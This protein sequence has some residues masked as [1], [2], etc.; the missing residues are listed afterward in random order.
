LSLTAPQSQG[1]V[2]SMGHHPTGGCAL[3]PVLPIVALVLFLTV[4][5]RAELTN[6][7]DSA[8]SASS[9]LDDEISLRGAVPSERLRAS[10]L[11]AVR[12][13][14]DR[15]ALSRALHEADLL[16]KRREA[17]EFD[18]E[19]RYR[20]PSNPNEAHKRIQEEFGPDSILTRSASTVA[21]IADG[22]ERGG[23]KSLDGVATVTES[24]VNRGGDAL[25]FDS[26]DMPRIKPRISGKRAGVYVSTDW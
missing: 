5:A 4:P 12:S 22:V 2:E 8:P 3:R 21:A 7:T 9:A 11:D 24:L 16:R 10:D 1:D 15:A 20:A 6:S 23:A 25:G 19:H 18:P 13:V 14:N 17:G 26:I